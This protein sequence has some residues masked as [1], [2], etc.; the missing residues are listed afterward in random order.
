MSRRRR[1]PARAARGRGD[2][3]ARRL[4]A[5]RRLQ[6]IGRARRRNPKPDP[7]LGT[8]ATDEEIERVQSLLEDGYTV[9]LTPLA[10]QVVIA[11]VDLDKL[12]AL[13]GDPRTALH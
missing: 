10:D 6:A 13:I 5:L 11:T 9:M 3:R 1:R 2:L 7:H 4:R 8:T 12:A